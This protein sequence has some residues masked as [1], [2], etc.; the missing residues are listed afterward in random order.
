MLMGIYFNKKCLE[1][2]TCLLFSLIISVYKK[3]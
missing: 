2:T 1:E 3:L